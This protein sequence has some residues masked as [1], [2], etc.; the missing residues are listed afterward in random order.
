MR[1]RPTRALAAIVTSASLLIPLS[2][3][4]STDEPIVDQTGAAEEPDLQDFGSTDS[5]IVSGTVTITGG[6]SVAGD[7]RN[8]IWTAQPTCEDAAEFGSGGGG[9]GPTGSYLIPGPYFGDPLSDGTEYDTTLELSDYAG[10]GTYDSVDYNIT[11][12]GVTT[13]TQWQVSEASSVSVTVL[14]DGSGSLEFTDAPSADGSATSSG[15]IVWDCE[16][17]EL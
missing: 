12:G 11:I 14:P 3:C 2:G 9:F 10:P 7:F 17:G 5:V 16:V 8:G 4:G 1:T 13:G 15:E 6:A